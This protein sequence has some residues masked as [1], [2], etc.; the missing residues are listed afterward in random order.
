MSEGPAMAVVLVGAVACAVAAA[1]CVVLVV[2]MLLAS[3][4][5][6]AAD[7]LD[8]AVKHDAAGSVG[9]DG[10]S[11]GDLRGRVLPR[12]CVM[13]ERTGLARLKPRGRMALAA[14]DRDSSDTNKRSYT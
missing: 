8:T 14:D 10:Q 13:G 2:R 3:G 7:V 1:W 9:D 12:F 5:P 11:C 6:G 4:L